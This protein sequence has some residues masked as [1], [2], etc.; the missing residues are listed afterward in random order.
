MVQRWLVVYSQAA[1]ECAETTLKT[2]TPREA[3]AI[4][5]QRLHFQAQRF[6]IPQDAHEA[7]AV[8]AKDWRYHRVASAQLTA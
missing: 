8:F 4:Q 5:K 1:F 6:G 7:L 3:E 2:A